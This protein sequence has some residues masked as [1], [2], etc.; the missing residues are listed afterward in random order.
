MP[1]KNALVAVLALCL[2]GTALGATGECMGKNCETV[3]LKGT[4]RVVGNEPFARLVL[5]VPDPREG[6]RP[7]DHLVKGP[8][9]E[10]IRN[11]H[12]GEVITVEGR[13]CAD[14]GPGNRPCFE[15]EKI[16]KIE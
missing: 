11:R 4:V 3:T 7:T 16:L 12:Q 8:L 9:A 5:T 13:Y 14:R 1:G 2:L 15:P 6:G 10:E